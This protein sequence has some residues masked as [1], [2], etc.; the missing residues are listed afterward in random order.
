MT[1]R[2]VVTARAALLSMFRW[3]GGHADLWPVL[4]CADALA[5]V[6]RGLAGPSGR[7]GWPP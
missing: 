4:R 6:D 1:E 2:A 7:R 5:V 3:D